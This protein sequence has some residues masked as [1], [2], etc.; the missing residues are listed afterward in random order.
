[1]LCY[2]LLS[3][4]LLARGSVMWYMVNGACGSSVVRLAPWLIRISSCIRY[5]IVTGTFSTLLLCSI[6]C[7]WLCGSVMVQIVGIDSG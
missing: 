7:K 5:C 1:M 2:V 6:V 3:T 4:P